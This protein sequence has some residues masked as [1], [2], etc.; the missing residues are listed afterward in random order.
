[1]HLHVLYILHISMYRFFAALKSNGSAINPLFLNFYLTFLY[2]VFCDG[3][4][5]FF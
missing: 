2:F 4:Y 5:L 1:M 3:F